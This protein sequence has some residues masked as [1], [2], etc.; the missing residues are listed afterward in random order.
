[1]PEKNYAMH[2]FG[3]QAFLTM[4]FSLLQDRH[5]FPRY[6]NTVQNTVQSKPILKLQLKGALHWR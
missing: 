1:M 4:H 5:Y 3:K 2:T 6:R